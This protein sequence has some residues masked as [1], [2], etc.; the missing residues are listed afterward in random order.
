VTKTPRITIQPIVPNPAQ[1]G[2]K[3]RAKLQF[4]CQI[5]R[6]ITRGCGDC[7]KFGTMENL[8]P[9]DLQ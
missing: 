1:N 6:K 9:I 2:A 3:T 8:Y 4:W 5:I 7:G